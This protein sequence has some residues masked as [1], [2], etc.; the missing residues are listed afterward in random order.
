MCV[1]LGEVKLP[2]HTVGRCL[3]IVLAAEMSNLKHKLLWL[4]K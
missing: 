1:G 2:T 4:F 3:H